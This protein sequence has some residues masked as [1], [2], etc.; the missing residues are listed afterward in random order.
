MSDTNEILEYKNF[1][2]FYKNLYTRLFD[3]IDLLIDEKDFN[4]KKVKNKVI[5]F[6]DSYS[7]YLLKQKMITKEDEVKSKL[8][9]LE[10]LKN[11]NQFFEPLT[12]YP[13]LD[14]IKVRYEYLRVSN[15]LTKLSDINYDT[16]IKEYYYFFEDTL[17]IIK[18]F[19]SISSD[20][21]FLPNIKSKTAIKTIGYANYDLFFT[22]LEELK[23]KVSD[24]TSNIDISN[25]FKSRRCCYCI[26][27]VFSP[28]FKNK[29]VQEILESSLNFKFLED[30]EI[31]INI[32]K[33]SNYSTL[34]VELIQNLERDLLSNLKSNISN[35]KRFISYEFG[36]MDMSP[37]IKKKYAYDP[38]NV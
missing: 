3:L 1:F 15:V 29:E 12:K 20:C 30:K 11:F 38:T 10:E 25:S 27:L 35:I 7:Y 14:Y 32:R 16:F 21:G 18:K 2:L 22:K 34:P 19:I 26:L 24:I 37:K 33:A 4:I 8:Y 6:L 23:L 9:L 28:Y 17:Q 31:M 36:E 5:D 13:S